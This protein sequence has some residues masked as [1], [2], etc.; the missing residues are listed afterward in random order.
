MPDIKGRKDRDKC[1][2]HGLYHNPY[3]VLA[4][5][6]AS[7]FALTLL[8]MCSAPARADLGAEFVM[9]G[10]STSVIRSIVV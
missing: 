3:V 8:I 10:R 9:K 5:R 7:V 2:Q 1:N 4:F 6:E